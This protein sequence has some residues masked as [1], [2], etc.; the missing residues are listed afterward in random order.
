MIESIAPPHKTTFNSTILRAV[1]ALLL[2]D[3]EIRNMTGK[4]KFRNPA[5]RY[6]LSEYIT[7]THPELVDPS[8]IP[9]SVAAARI[10][11][12]EERNKTG[13]RWN[14]LGIRYEHKT[15]LSV[16]H[17]RMFAVRDDIDAI[18]RVLTEGFQTALITHEED[19]A[20][21]AAGYRSSVPQDGSDR[22]QAAGIEFV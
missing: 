15:P 4:T 7:I 10:L 8:Y 22:Y 12:E 1:Q 16:L 2:A 17:D 9:R 11:Q 20:I 14:K 6:A 18:D 13:Q 3:A 5:M 21:N 19:K